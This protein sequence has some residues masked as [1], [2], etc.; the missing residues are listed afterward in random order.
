MNRVQSEFLSSELLSLMIPLS[1]TSNAF[2]AH[3]TVHNRY[4]HPESLLLLKY[5]WQ[6]I[7][8]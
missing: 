5:S 8:I 4:G 3:G 2:L 6:L 1:L 7:D